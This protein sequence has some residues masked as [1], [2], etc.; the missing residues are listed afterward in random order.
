MFAVKPKVGGLKYADT[1][2]MKVG[3]VFIGEEEV[4]V[5]MRGRD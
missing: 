2:F 5:H 1:Y 3:G 4:L